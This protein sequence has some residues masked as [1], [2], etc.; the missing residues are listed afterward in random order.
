MVLTPAEIALGRRNF[1]KALAG[2][3]PLIAF[4]AAA[5]LRG[6]KTG[7]PVRAGFIGPGRQG[8]VLLGQCRKE[9]IDLRAVCDINP[10]RLDEASDSLV[11]LGW[12]APHKYEE[13]R[14][15]LARE[16]IEA[17]IIATP[18][19]SHAEMTVGLLGEIHHARLMYHRNRSWRRD[20]PPPSAEYSPARWGY[21]RGITSS[22][23]AC[24]ASTPRGW[25][26]SSAGTR[27][28][29]PT[30][31]S[32]PPRPRSWEAAASIASRT[33]RSTTTSS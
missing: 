23:G 4:G 28:A 8:K 32:T 30:S 10:Q 1:M 12:A 25:W 3:P 18:L 29:R 14:D 26:P 15:M 22:T 24:T 2:V 27:S 5:A 31:S 6:P 19:W 7:G 13:W 33:V 17:V 20:T 9:F 16:D 21:P 11:K